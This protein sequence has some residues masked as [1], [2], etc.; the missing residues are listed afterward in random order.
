MYNPETD[1]LKE[2]EFRKLEYTSGCGGATY[3]WCYKKNRQ[4]NVYEDCKNCE[5]ASPK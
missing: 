4:I 3:W 1:E 5:E 2:C